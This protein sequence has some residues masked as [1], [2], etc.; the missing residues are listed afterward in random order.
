MKVVGIIISVSL[1]LG[2]SGCSQKLE[3]HFCSDNELRIWTVITE[4]GQYNELASS[5][6]LEFFL[7]G[8]LEIQV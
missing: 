2:I 8:T 3:N 1:L 6:S 4:E 7:M 5:D